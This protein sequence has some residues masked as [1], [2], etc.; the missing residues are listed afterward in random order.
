MSEK[1]TAVLLIDMQWSFVRALQEKDRERIVSHQIEIIRCCARETIP[2]FVCEYRTDNESAGITFGRTIPELE[3]EIELLKP[4]QVKRINKY[5]NSAFVKTSLLKILKQRK[6]TDL[7]LMGINAD[8]CV[9]ETAIDAREAGFSVATSEGVIATSS[10]HFDLTVRWYRKN[11]ML[12]W[13]F[14]AAL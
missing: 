6:I 8:Y 2:L 1:R 14:V 7:F 9:Q 10:P 3:N 11:G 12:V 4:R 13:P 5:C